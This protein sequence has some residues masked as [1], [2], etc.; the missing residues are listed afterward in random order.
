MKPCPP[1][2]SRSGP[3]GKGKRINKN[4]KQTNGDGCQGKKTDF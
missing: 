2:G 3:A 1:D 4:N